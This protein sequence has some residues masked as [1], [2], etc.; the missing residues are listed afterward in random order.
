MYKSSHHSGT[1]IS[2][3]IMFFGEA[4]KKKTALVFV[5][6]VLICLLELNSV[7]GA[8]KRVVVVVVAG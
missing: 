5:C 8:P 7:C 6:D 1:L 3:Y 2:G 4:E